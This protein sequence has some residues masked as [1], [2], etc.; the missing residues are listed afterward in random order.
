MQ[1]TLMKRFMSLGPGFVYVLTILGTGDMVTNSAAGAGYGYALIWAL[2]LTL[3]FRYVWVNTSAKYVL[4]TGE[5][6]MRGYARLG[7]WFVWVMLVAL[8]F[9]RHFYNL[10]QL[11]MMGQGADLLLHLPTEWSYKIWGLSFTLVGFAMMYWGGY[12]VV[13][14]FCKVLVGLM[15]T[16]MVVAA[17]LS[18]PDPT[19]IVKGMFIP[20]IPGQQGIYSALLVLMA[21]IGTEAGSMTNLTYAYFVYEKGWRNTDYLKQQRFDL[22]FGVICLFVMGTLLQVAAA[23]TVGEQGVDLENADDLVRIFSETQGLVGTI[24]FGLGLW[25]AAFSTFVGGTTGYALIITD[26]CRNF[27]PG[28]KQSAAEKKANKN[29]KDDPIYRWSIIFWSFS[30]LY[31]LLVEVRPVWLVL[32]FSS[33]FVLMIP[34]LALALVK[35]TNDESLMGKY[36]NGWFTNTVLGL[37]VAVALYFTWENAGGLLSDLGDLLQNSGLF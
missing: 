31:I 24:I 27:I 16:S 19:G 29:V 10:Y 8:I 32:M 3:I 20:T 11:I 14:I 34:V 12:L 18:N 28:F 5:S 21:L 26:L 23:G 9:F 17:I 6:L 37:L 33:L 25:G 30:P 4:V 15:G 35:I 2:G 36:K 13:E 7:N 22:G 1:P